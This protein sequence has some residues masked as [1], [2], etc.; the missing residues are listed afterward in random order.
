M[1][2]IPLVIP[3]LSHFWLNFSSA[4]ANSSDFAQQ[5]LAGL[6]FLGVLPLMIS[7]SLPQ[8]FRRGA[9]PEFVRY[10]QGRLGVAFV[11]EMQTGADNAAFLQLE[12]HVPGHQPYCASATLTLAADALAKVQPGAMLSV[13]A[14]SNDVNLFKIML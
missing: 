4:N 12:V 9:R 6:T 8:L 1:V 13:L 14:N 7:L 10:T 5:L 2:N 3:N 11:R